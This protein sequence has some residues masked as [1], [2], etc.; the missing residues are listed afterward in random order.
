M[1]RVIQVFILLDL[2]DQL[3]NVHLGGT[4]ELTQK[5]TFVYSGSA[6]CRYLVEV[7]YTYTVT[8][9]S[10][11]CLGAVVLRGDVVAHGIERARH[12][13]HVE[14]PPAAALMSCSFQF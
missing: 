13:A 1:C 12:D 4:E 2:R 9:Y 10:W 11:L 14:A 6:S 3:Y 7:M 8:L 5:K